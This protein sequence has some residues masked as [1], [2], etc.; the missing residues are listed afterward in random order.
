MDAGL[1]TKDEALEQLEEFFISCNRDSDLYIGI[2]QGDNGQTIVLGGSN[3]DGSDAYNEL[4]ELCLLASRDLCL[5][6]PKV[7]LRVHKNTPLS[8][9]ELAT[10]LTK[11]GLGFPQYTN[12]EIVVPA[13]LRWGYDEAGRVQLHAGRLLGDPCAGLYGPRQLGQPELPQVRAGRL[14]AAAQVRNL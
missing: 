12:D 9:Y 13:L 8:V 10:T 6:D 11:K 1:L 2:Q 5:I 14:R 4:S 7:N 3:A